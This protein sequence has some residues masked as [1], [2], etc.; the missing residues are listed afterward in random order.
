MNHNSHNPNFKFVIDP[1]EF[2]KNTTSGSYVLQ[3]IKRK[4]SRD[5]N[6]EKKYLRKIQQS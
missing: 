3:G 4:I 2:N 5:W 6:K 1:V